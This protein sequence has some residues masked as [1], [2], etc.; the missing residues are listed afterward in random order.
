M[1]KNPE[2]YLPEKI[3]ESFL[4]ASINIDF[5]GGMD[6]IRMSGRSTKDNAD[7]ISAMVE[8]AS[9]KGIRFSPGEVSVLW[10]CLAAKV[11]NEAMSG[12]TAEDLETLFKK[13]DSAVEK[14]VSEHGLDPAR[15][16]SD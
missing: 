12:P 2:Y 6:N 1:R 13:A 5:P 8:E 7:L 3:L 4:N 14:L 15:D 9:E 16:F 10:T 11:W